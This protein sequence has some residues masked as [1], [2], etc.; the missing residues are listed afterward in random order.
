MTSAASDLSKLC[1]VLWPGQGPT[2]LVE[3]PALAR[4]CGVAWIGAK[5]EGRRPLGSFKSLGG[6]CGSLLTLA[7][8]TGAPNVEAL[9]RPGGGHALPTLICASDGNHG[10][11]VAAA[12]ARVGTPARIYLHPGVPQAR[13]R[14]IREQGAQV[15]IVEGT[16]DDAVTQA[17]AA[18]AAGQGLLIPDTSDDP[19]CPVVADV[20][21][22][23]DVLAAELAG[24]LG[25]ERPTHL[26]VQAGVGGLA[27]ALAA[28]LAAR[29]SPSPR[30][31]VVEPA[32]AACVSAALAAGRLRQLDGDL[33]TAAEMLSCGLASAPALAVLRRHD[34][35]AVAVDEAAL[36]AGP[37]RLA[38]SGG[39]VTTPSGA[40]GLAGLLAAVPG[41][42]Q[43]HAFGVSAESRI[44]L[45]VTEGPVPAG[46][47]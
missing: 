14:R 42:A 13:V 34:A 28:G 35:V 9:L 27:A 43:G 32:R 26:F 15:V 5:D 39:P 6:T 16:Y 19:D 1:A 12:G 29:L 33:E 7:R 8:I 10:L 18:A 38:E 20:M 17:A 2:P 21:A 37:R 11:A 25:P 22:G 36:E 46:V 47:V 45:I 24:Q 23:Y 30:T 4:D 44:L 3:L 40:A 31:V 41:S